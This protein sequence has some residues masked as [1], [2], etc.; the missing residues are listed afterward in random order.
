MG[1]RPDHRPWRLL[2]C[3]DGTESVH[4][5][6]GCCKDH[7]QNRRRKDS[8]HELSQ[9]RPKHRQWIVHALKTKGHAPWTRA[10]DCHHEASGSSKH[11]QT[12]RCLGKPERTVSLSFILLEYL[13]GFQNL[14][15]KI[16][17]LI[18]I[19]H[20][21]RYIIME[22][23]EGGELFDYIENQ[24]GLSEHEAVFLFRQIIEALIYCH[25]IN[26]HHRDLKPENIL[27]DPETYSIKL[28]DFGMAA[29]Q[30]KGQFLSTPCGSPHYAAPELLVNKPYD[31]AQSDVWSCGVI[32]YVMLTGSPPFNFPPDSEGMSDEE[33]LK[34]LYSL[35]CRAEYSVPK[36]LSSEFHDLI[37]KI[38]VVDPRQ[39]ITMTQIWNH[40]LLH[41][42]D[43]RYGFES[44][45]PDTLFSSSLHLNNWV[46][47]TRTSIDREILR[48][49]R[50]L[51]HSEKEESLIEKLLN[52]DEN[53]E[54]FFYSALLRNREEQ[55]ENYAGYPASIV[56]SPSD[57]QHLTPFSQD[58]KKRRSGLPA[59]L[60]PVSRTKSQYSILND[61]HL[62]SRYSLYSSRLSTHA[63]SD[64]VQRYQTAWSGCSD[65]VSSVGFNV[66]YKAPSPVS[67]ASSP[68]HPELKAK[69]VK[70]MPPSENPSARA[71]LG[72]SVSPRKRTSG[73]QRS[74]ISLDNTSTNIPSSPPIAFVAPNSHDKRPIQLSYVYRQSVGKPSPLKP[75][76]EEQTMPPRPHVVLSAHEECDTTP[77]IFMPENNSSR[78]SSVSPPPTSFLCVEPRAEDRT[79]L[80]TE[81]TPEKSPASSKFC[82][83]LEKFCEDIFFG[84]S[85]ESSANMLSV[86]QQPLFKCLETPPTSISSGNSH[87]VVPQG[88][89]TFKNYPPR[90]NEKKND[91]DCHR[92]SYQV[93]V[94]A[95]APE[96]PKSFASRQILETRERLAAK[97][98]ET[99]GNETYY[100]DIIAQ[101]DNLLQNQTLIPN[102]SARTASAPPIRRTL[103]YDVPAGSGHLPVIDEESQHGGGDEIGI[104]TVGTFCGVRRNRVVTEPIRPTVCKEPPSDFESTIR[105]IDP[106]SSATSFKPSI[107]SVQ[108]E[109]RLECCTPRSDPSSHLGCGD[110]SDFQRSGLANVSKNP[111]FSPRLRPLDT[112]KA[113][114]EDFL[115]MPRPSS[116]MPFSKEK[117]SES[118]IR[119]ASS[120]S[121]HRVLGKK[122]SRFWRKSSDRL[123]DDSSQRYD[124]WNQLSPFNYCSRAYILTC[125]LSVQYRAAS[126]LA[127]CDVQPNQPPSI[128]QESCTN[129]DAHNSYKRSGGFFQFF[130][131]KKSIPALNS[132][133]VDEAGEYLPNHPVPIFGTTFFSERT[134]TKEKWRRSGINT[135][136]APF[137]LS[138]NTSQEFTSCLKP[139]QLRNCTGGSQPEVQIN[140]ISRLLH[141]KP[142]SYIICLQT[143]RTRALQE[144]LNILRELQKWGGIDIRCDHVSN[145]IEANVTRKTSK[146]QPVPL[147]GHGFCP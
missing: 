35:I 62:H 75:H 82:S 121:G 37:E 42:H 127:F 16:F 68:P 118:D 128:S 57:Y 78:S 17:H 139:A 21:D 49:M 44:S 47:L 73:H 12:L 98:A 125:L 9:S 107:Y 36:H 20:F 89:P 27:M 129:L 19:F 122:R 24:R 111:P 90:W 117:N 77:T 109:K 25:Q 141:V 132:H 61:E 92:P 48:N 64:S 103:D 99:S 123:K 66:A 81:Q 39:R 84:S 94:P 30:P 14:S 137:C 59:G 60:P 69:I 10:G 95:E 70:R 53:Q 105:L 147:V 134:L 91:C 46:P 85:V 58:P 87:L 45:R 140:W 67:D 72:R 71:S 6:T 97:W 120:M 76:Q 18:L 100:R 50:T 1:T 79:P 131:K 8:C 29:L 126:A 135:H 51:W 83:D 80:P 124:A 113:S 52:K 33:G 26:I 114:R 11:R 136:Q 106:S 86:S 3:E 110:S 22:Y 55:L 56:Y 74:N 40:P 102:S 38:F 115:E 5:T 31:G 146:C 130:R 142:I 93:S 2:S 119:C 54:K 43:E 96:T 7:I 63:D 32:L 145:I 144:L 4:R 34:A 13:E 65:N 15:S 28:V 104:N 23:V 116:A 88:S 143:S 101:L 138:T 112:L 108:D 41:K 133:G